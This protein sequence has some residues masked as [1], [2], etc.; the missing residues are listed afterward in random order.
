[1]P[2]ATIEDAHKFADKNLI[3]K[4]FENIGN[5]NSIIAFQVVPYN[6]NNKMK[7]VG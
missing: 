7:L 1:M 4:K 2:F 6:S 5:K 3:G